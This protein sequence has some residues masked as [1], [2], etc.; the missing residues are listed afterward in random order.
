MGA[1]NTYPQKG[2][3]NFASPRRLEQPDVSIPGWTQKGGAIE[4]VH[5]N[6]VDGTS[7]P[8]HAEF[9]RARCAIARRR[10]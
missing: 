7:V 8:A 10:N 4:I 2:D 9:V 6:Q 3:L 5:F 1:G